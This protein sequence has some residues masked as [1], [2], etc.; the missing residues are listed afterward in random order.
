MACTCPNINCTQ[1]EE[2]GITYCDCTT[3]ITNIQCPPGCTV[4]VQPD[5]NAKCSCKDSIDPEIIKEKTPIY[6]DNKEYFEDVSWTIAFKAGQ[7]WSSYFTFYPDYSVTYLDY[8]QVGYNWD[9]FK[10]SIWTHTL[11]NKSFQ[12][13]QGKLNPMI[14]EFPIVNQ[15]TNK[16]FNVVS[17]NIESKRWQNKWDFSQHPEIGFNKAL[18]YNNTNNSHNLDLIEQKTLSQVSSYPKTKANSQEI[19]FTAQDEKHTFNYFYNRVIDERNN[20]PHFNWDKNRI[21]KTVN[22]KA[23]S[24]YGKPQLER[25]RGEAA[26]VQLTNDKESRFN[27]ALKNTINKTTDY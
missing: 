25:I 5:G 13:F 19:L 17:L 23:V 20:I 2:S 26:I 1:R 3:I 7:G 4:V 10:E 16:I 8:F 18:I 6:F 15:N 11:G 12:V 14:V 9:R 22:P 21:F 24:F 27:I